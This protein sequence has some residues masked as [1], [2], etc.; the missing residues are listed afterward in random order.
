MQPKFKPL[1]TSIEPHS[2]KY[3]DSV[4]QLNNYRII[5]TDNFAKLN[6]FIWTESPLLAE[7]SYHYVTNKNY[8]N[9]LENFTLKQIFKDLIIKAVTDKV[10]MSKTMADSDLDRLMQLYEYCYGTSASEKLIEIKKHLNTTVSNLTDYVTKPRQDLMVVKINERVGCGAFLDPKANP[11]QENEIVTVYTGIYKNFEQ[12]N[13]C[14]DYAFD[15]PQHPIFYSQNHAEKDGFNAGFIDAKNYGN[16]SR[17]IQDLP[18]EDEIKEL[19]K[20]RTRK[21]N[22]IA[23]ANIKG[24]LSYCNNVPVVYLVA[25]REIQPGEQLGFSYGRGYWSRAELI[26]NIKRFL[27]DK[28][29]QIIKPDKFI[30]Y[31]NLVKDNHY[32]C[33]PKA[34]LKQQIKKNLALHF[35][36]KV[37]G[38][39][40]NITIGVQELISIFKKSKKIKRFFSSLLKVFDK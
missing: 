9:E 17:F 24:L 35:V 8:S 20:L 18:T 19:Y 31:I 37:N 34:K 22:T 1:F 38:K 4:D 16:I 33:F 5:K 10:T 39:L 25:T 28:N 12:R 30:N 14:E 15:L 32:Y 2:V 21:L 36:S 7:E 11:I 23:T 13:E 40:E 3:A 6:N 27:F 26:K 29:G